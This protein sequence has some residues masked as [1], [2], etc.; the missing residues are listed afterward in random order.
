MHEVNHVIHAT[1]GRQ[2]PPILWQECREGDRGGA[3]AK[4]SG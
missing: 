3:L 4:A 2:C 1:E